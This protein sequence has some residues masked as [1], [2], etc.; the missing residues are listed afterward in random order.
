MTVTGT[1]Q[2]VI[3][4]D[5]SMQ[6]ASSLHQL[7]RQKQLLAIAPHGLDVKTNILAVPLEHL[8]Q[9]HA[10]EINKPDFHESAGQRQGS[11]FD[12]ANLA[13]WHK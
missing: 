2:D 7:Q 10:A 13:R 6:D 8:S 9:V 4:F 1:H 5:V 3:G 12:V 11:N